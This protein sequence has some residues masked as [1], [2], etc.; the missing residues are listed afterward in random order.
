MGNNKNNITNYMMKRLNELS[1]DKTNL[2]LEITKA[3]LD[4]NFTDSLIERIESIETEELELKKYVKELDNIYLKEELNADT[5]EDNCGIKILE[6]QENERQRIARELHDSTVQVLTNLVHKTELC[7]R[8]MDM[9]PI[10]AKLELEIINNNIRYTIN[11]MRNIIHN[12]RPMAFD[13]FGWDITLERVIAQIK[14]SAED[15]NIHLHIIGEKFNIS[16]I[17]AL[18]LV[19]IIQEACNNSIKH[20]KA[21]NIFVNF[22]YLLN[23]I[24]ISINDDGIGFDPNMILEVNDGSGFGISIMKER[25]MLL[26]GKLNITSEKNK[27][28]TLIIDVP[29]L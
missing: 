11:D 15:V 29:V 10:R 5:L 3:K 17:T 26:S 16:S 9:D 21:N 20:A 25:T 22:E 13:D 18:T 1:I 27:G 28:T 19:R 14:N 8:V 7:M 23:A 4:R 24:R 12:L 6:K 2:R